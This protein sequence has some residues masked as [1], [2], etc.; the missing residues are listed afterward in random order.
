MVREPDVKIEI[1]P[2]EEILA[3]RTRALRPHFEPG[4]LAHFEGDEC[5]DSLHVAA[6][7]GGDVIGCVTFMRRPAPFAPEEPAI[8]LRGMA[9]AAARRGEGVGARMLARGMDLLAIHAS[10]ARVLWCNARERA[11]PFYARQGFV[12]HGEYFDVPV[13]GPHV[14]MWRELPLAIA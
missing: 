7:E 6:R 12:T 1:V 10:P 3:L 2:I 8:Q 4:Q 9:V 11:V 5:E 13:I 14:V